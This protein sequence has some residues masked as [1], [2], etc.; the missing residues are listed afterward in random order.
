MIPEYTGAATTC[1]YDSCNDDDGG[2]GTDDDGEY[3]LA[4]PAY[5]RGST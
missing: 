1:F 3:C 2:G 4:I 5:R